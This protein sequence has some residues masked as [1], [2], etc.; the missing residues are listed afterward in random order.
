MLVLCFDLLSFGG[1]ELSS[2][3]CGEPS[4]AWIAAMCLA[5]CTGPAGQRDGV[6]YS[7]DSLSWQC[8]LLYLNKLGVVTALVKSEMTS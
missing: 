8:H 4:Q 1:R 7:A 6:G 5:G 3:Y 2:K